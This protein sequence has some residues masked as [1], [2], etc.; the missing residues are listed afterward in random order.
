MSQVQKVENIEEKQSGTT[1]PA[2]APV[3]PVKEKFAKLAEPA[4]QFKES[5]VKLSKFKFPGNDAGRGGLPRDAKGTDGQPLLVDVPSSGGRQ[6]L[7]RLVA[8]RLEAMNRKWL[9]D[10]GQ[11]EFKVA[12]GWRKPAFATFAEYHNW[13][14]NKNYYLGPKWGTG[15]ATQTPSYQGTKKCEVAKAFYSP[16]ETG[17]AIDFGNNGLK[18]TM[19]TNSIQKQ[20]PAYVWLTENAHLFGITPYIKEAWHWEVQMPLESWITGEDWVEGENYAVRIKGPGR[21]GKLPPG[22][23]GNTTGGP[24]RVRSTVGTSNGPTPDLTTW[25]KMEPELPGVVGGARFPDGNLGGKRDLGQINEL[26]IHE[27]AGGFRQIK[28]SGEGGKDSVA[29]RTLGKRGLS[30]HFTILRTGQ[31][32][33]HAPLDTKTFASSPKNNNSIGVD[34]INP[35]I[36]KKK[37]SKEDYVNKSDQ[38]TAY[39]LLDKGFARSGHLLNTPAQC[40]ALWQ[41]IKKLETK[42]PNFKIVFPSADDGGSFAPAKGKNYKDPGIVAHVRWHH[43]DGA[44]AE[45]YCLARSSGISKMEAWY[46][47]VGAAAKR[48]LGEK[49]PL[50]STGNAASLASLGKEKLKETRE[51]YKKDTA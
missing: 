1:A 29:V 43:A 19:S 26:V 48:G 6:K 36:V 14:R 10:G 15:A 27:T 21:T 34:L 47:S 39:P 4:E 44:F 50:P 16:H 35:V 2:Q 31:I 17:L 24:C 25:A 51:K 49:I 11:Q 13:C 42:L 32:K 45:Y 41:L 46:A 37:D 33:Q 8:K 7:H 3:V 23:T 38:E 9:A 20:T 22:F 12:S 5:R 28:S 30:T 40:E 18:P